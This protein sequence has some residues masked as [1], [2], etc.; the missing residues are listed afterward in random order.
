MGSLNF[1]LMKNDK[2]RHQKI[3]TKDGIIKKTKG[4]RKM[5]PFSKNEEPKWILDSNA[6][7]NFKRKSKKEEIKNANRSLKK[8]IR[9]QLKK[10]LKNQIDKSL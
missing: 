4:V 5:K 7:P 6:A 3:K 8:G 10:D 9:Q 1:N 2:K